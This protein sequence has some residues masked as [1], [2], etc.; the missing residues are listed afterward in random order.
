MI[1]RCTIAGEVLGR[2]PFRGGGLLA[3]DA[4]PMTMAQAGK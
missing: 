1:V 2:R 4:R 3:R